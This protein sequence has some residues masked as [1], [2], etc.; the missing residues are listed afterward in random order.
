MCVCVCV[1]KVSAN[2][3]YIKMCS[4]ICSSFSTS[5]LPSCVVVIF[6]DM[7]AYIL[8]EGTNFQKFLKETYAIALDSCYLL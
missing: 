2:K 5:R 1:P 3:A 6:I 4:R 7:N 8:K